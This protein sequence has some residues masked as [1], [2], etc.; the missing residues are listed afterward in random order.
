[1]TS[2]VA[3]YKYSDVLCAERCWRSAFFKRL[4][5]VKTVATERLK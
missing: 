1:M 4:K 2:V 5:T 3:G